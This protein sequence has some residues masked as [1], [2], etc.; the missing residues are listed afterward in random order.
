VVVD[1]PL[2]SRHPRHPDLTYPVNYGFI[3]NT[4]TGDL[5]PIDAYVLGID[6][7]VASFLG[8]VI[9]IV[10][11]RDVVEDTLVVAPAGTRLSTDEIADAVRFQ[12]RFFDG[13]IVM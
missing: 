12:E 6:V 10:A 8:E 1:R 11:R 4:R 3:P 2:D 9:A 7:P 13:E 5:D